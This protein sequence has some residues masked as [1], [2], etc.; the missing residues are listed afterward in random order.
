VWLL[1]EIDDTT[2]RAR[3]RRDGTHE[4]S[5]AGAYG[6]TDREVEVLRLVADGLTNAEIAARLFISPKT[7]SVHVSNVLRKLEVESR[8]EAGRLARSAGITT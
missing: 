7:A 1:A 8:R 4:R 5:A 2:R 3:L 6:L